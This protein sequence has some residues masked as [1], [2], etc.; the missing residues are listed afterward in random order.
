MA[1]KYLKYTPTS[2]LKSTGFLLFTG[3]FLLFSCKN[4]H[5]IYQSEC[6][7]DITFKHIGFTQLIDSIQKYDQQYIEVVGKYREGKE[8]SAL[9][10][11]SL[12]VDHSNGHSLWVN[13]SQDCP[14]YLLG[15]RKGLFEYNDGKFTRISNKKITIRGRVDLRHKGHLGSYRA[16]IDR[17]SFVKL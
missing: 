1:F 12:F 4:E 8:E 9:V 14:L 10:N 15:T 17:V 16:T 7:S 3:I 6:D 2:Y 5:K 13:F 11:D